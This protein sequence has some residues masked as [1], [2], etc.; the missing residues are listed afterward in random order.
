V[1]INELLFEV[2]PDYT[3]IGQMEE[4]A[5]EICRVVCRE[6]DKAKS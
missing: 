5:V 1:K 6:W 4:I 3:T 2:L